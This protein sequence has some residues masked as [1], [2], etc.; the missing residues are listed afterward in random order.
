MRWAPDIDDYETPMT[1]L[2]DKIA[3]DETIESQVDGGGHQWL[4]IRT[5]R[6]MISIHHTSPSA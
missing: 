1:V 5:E 6:D 3:T 2:R 4:T